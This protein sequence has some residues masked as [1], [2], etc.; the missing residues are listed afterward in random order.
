MSSSRALKRLERGAKAALL[1]LIRAAVGGGRR[2]PPPNWRSR[3]HRVLFV[4]HD[5]IG[6]VL[7][8]TPLLRAIAQAHPTI[9]IDVLTMPGPAEALRGL[10]FLRSVRAFR[11]GRR[12]TYPRD[13][14]AAVRR[15]R[16]DA[17][18]DGTVRRFVDGQEFGT[19]VKAAM[20]LL[21]LASGARH[22]IGMAG[23]ENDFVY[24]IPV[25]PKNADAH[26]SAYT[27]SLGVPFGLDPLAIDTRPALA[28]TRDERGA[29]E[30]Q[31]SGAALEGRPRLLVN[32]SSLNECRRWS[33][34][35]YVAAL[36]SIRA[37]C[38]DVAVAVIAGPG[39]RARALAI[40]QQVD[41]KAMV[42]SLRV[43][44][45]VV[46]TATLLLTPDTSLGHAAAALGTPVVVLLPRGHEPLVPAGVDGIHLFGEGGRIDSIPPEPVA[47]AV[48]DMLARARRDG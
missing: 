14:L 3:A 13:V 42:P 22:R 35:A 46:A 9:S 15:E 5:G 31:W 32:I 47:R 30:R 24:T 20:L 10:P 41:A 25:A 2:S 48:L 8:S 1:G 6:D 12:L 34:D 37:E 11:P 17:V 36:R 19:R 7:M 44:F 40:A 27:A 39:E 4:R 23:R 16:Y 33:D 43:A 28:L 38:R 18:I 26:H 21:L 45:G 29:G